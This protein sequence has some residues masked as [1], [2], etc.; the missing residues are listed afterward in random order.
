M[1][2]TKDISSWVGLL[3]DILCWLLIRTI[4]E[5]ELLFKNILSGN[6]INDRSNRAF[7]KLALQSSKPSTFCLD[8]TVYK[9]NLF[10]I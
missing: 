3:G 8:D 2:I 4:T 1:Y 10:F 5:L 7:T 9:V 6:D